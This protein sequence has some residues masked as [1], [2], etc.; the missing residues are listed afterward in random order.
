MPEPQEPTLTELRLDLQRWMETRG[1]CRVRDLL[2]LHLLAHA[3]VTRSLESIAGLR[4]LHD[5]PTP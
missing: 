4:K 5:T 3:E 1:F 2:A